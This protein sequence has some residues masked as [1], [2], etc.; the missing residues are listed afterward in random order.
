M[1]RSSIDLKGPDD[2]TDD[3]HG[4]RIIRNGIVETGQKGHFNHHA[5]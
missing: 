3:R 1:N 2:R 5:G 4:T